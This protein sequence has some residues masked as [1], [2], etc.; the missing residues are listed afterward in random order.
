V[1][2][3]LFFG[4]RK[5]ILLLF[6]SL[7]DELAAATLYEMRIPKGFGSFVYLCHLL[8]GV[9]RV[10]LGKGHIKVLIINRIV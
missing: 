2:L 10:N 1:Q 9:G 7:F 4:G 6:I 3:V 8:R 5:L